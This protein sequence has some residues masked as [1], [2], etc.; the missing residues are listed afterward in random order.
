MPRL[1]HTYVNR[2]SCLAHGVCAHEAP[3]VFE[4]SE[5]DSQARA[6][7]GFQ[8][9]LGSHSESIRRAAESCPVAAIIAVYDDGTILGDPSLS[10][11]APA[12]PLRPQ[13][14]WLLWVLLLALGFAVGGSLLLG[15]P[16]SDTRL[17]LVLN[18][19]FQS[20]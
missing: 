1:V 15:R 12:L 9:L 17:Q 14:P 7:P 11:P 4:L 3:E 20:T 18:S 13:R 10:P 16:P 6:L 19:S 8:R 5:H 2:E